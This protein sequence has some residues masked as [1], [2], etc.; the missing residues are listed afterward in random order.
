VLSKHLH[1]KAGAK[2]ARAHIHRQQSWR[3]EDILMLNKSLG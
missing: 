1:R 3:M 2:F